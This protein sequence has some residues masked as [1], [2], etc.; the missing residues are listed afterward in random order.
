MKVIAVVLAVVVGVV[1][2]NAGTVPKHRG[3]Q[4][5]PTNEH[6][7]P[8]GP[9]TQENGL[10]SSR[11][12]G[13]IEKRGATS[14]LHRVNN[15]GY[16]N[17]INNPV[18]YDRLDDGYPNREQ[19]TEIANFGIGIAV[20]Q[21]QTKFS[22][23]RYNHGGNRHGGLGNVFNS[24]AG[25]MHGFHGNG[26][27]VHGSSGNSGLINGGNTGGYSQ[28]GRGINK[29]GASIGQSFNP[30]GS[31]NSEFHRPSNPS[32]PTT[33]HVINTENIHVGVPVASRPVHSR[34]KGYA[35]I[36]TGISTYRLGIRNVDLGANT[37]HHG[38]N[39]NNNNNNNNNIPYG[40]TK[41]LGVA[42]AVGED[43]EGR[44]SYGG[45]EVF[46]NVG[47]DYAASDAQGLP[48]KTGSLRFPGA[49]K[50]VPDSFENDQFFSGAANFKSHGTTGNAYTKDNLDN[51]GN[52]E[53]QVDTKGGRRTLGNG[54]E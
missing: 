49:P 32:L 23:V 16:G 25:L 36:N 6:R 14:G 12:D 18:T 30:F 39:N 24:N 34:L 35:D 4:D 50:A 51:H 29:I 27:F 2:V 52:N 22:P 3:Q 31:S 20:A 28:T 53:A 10:S 47:Q 41:H 38:L 46:G 11:K 9:L 21:R 15:V 19:L 45:N 8:K 44:S 1:V 13:N 37:A 42:F 33:G 26:G 40:Q 5:V 54:H 17:F 7:L 43:R 48:F